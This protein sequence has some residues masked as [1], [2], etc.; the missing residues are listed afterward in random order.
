MNYTARPGIDMVQGRELVSRII[1]LTCREFDVEE[2][3]I[4]EKRRH[5]RIVVPRHVCHYLLMKYTHMRITDI[6]KTI[7]NMH[8]AVL[9]NSKKY[10]EDS[11]F[12]DRSF[13]ERIEF[14]ENELNSNPVGLKRS[15][16]KKKMKL[17]LL[18]IRDFR[19]MS[20]M[21]KLEYLIN[22]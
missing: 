22:C 3:E 8:H 2:S 14:I 15:K 12:F 1:H 19:Y 17:G 7:S 5:Q 18:Q 21:D 13:R 6:A 4:R 10:V 11:M 20:H 9:Y 16:E